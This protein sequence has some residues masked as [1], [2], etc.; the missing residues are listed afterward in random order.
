MKKLFFTRK[1]RIIIFTSIFI[2]GVSLKLMGFEYAY[3]TTPSLE[4]K[5]FLIDTKNK[6]YEKESIIT[7]KYDKE[8]KYNNKKGDYL[9]KIV[10]CMQGEFLQFKD[11]SFYCNDK[12]IADFTDVDLDFK[13]VDPFFYSGVIPKDKIFVVGTHKYS[14]DSRTFGLI[15]RSSIVGKTIGIF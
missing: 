14:Y 12:K 7:F 15:D 5:H 13:K 11:N 3:S 1:I 2:L 10:K 8:P 9:T 4:Y 6:S